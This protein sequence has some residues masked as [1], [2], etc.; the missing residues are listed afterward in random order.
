MARVIR[1]I[2]LM[3]LFTNTPLFSPNTFI[4]DRQ[5]PQIA[6]IFHNY[7][8]PGDIAIIQNHQEIDPY[9]LAGFTTECQGCN[10]ADRLRTATRIAQGL[11]QGREIAPKVISANAKNLSS[12][13]A[14]VY[15]NS[16]PGQRIW[17]VAHLGDSNS[18]RIYNYIRWY[19][20]QNIKFLAK[21][22]EGVYAMFF[23]K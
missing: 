16:R 6:H 21:N 23:V 1:V 20:G 18:F 19:T 13:S 8:R 10:Y 2:F 3:L 9:W 15:Q 7:F 4:H 22:T 11:S 14:L 17:I 5:T 12:L